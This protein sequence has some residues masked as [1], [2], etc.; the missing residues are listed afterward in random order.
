MR[1]TYTCNSEGNQWD[2][3][4]LFIRMVGERRDI[5]FMKL[6]TEGLLRTK[7]AS[8]DGVDDRGVE[9]RS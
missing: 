6:V 7:P 8:L 1:G 2:R 3:E 5:E 9:V 4:L